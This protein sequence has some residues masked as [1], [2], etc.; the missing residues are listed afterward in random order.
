MSWWILTQ[1]VWGG[2]WD[3]SFLANVQ[4]MPMVLVHGSHFRKPCCKPLWV[5]LFVR[6]S[7]KHLKEYHFQIIVY[8]ALSPTLHPLPE[9]HLHEQKRDQCKHRV[10]FTETLLWSQSCSVM[11]FSE[12]KSPSSWPHGLYSPWNSPGQNTGVGSLSFL[13]GIFPTQGLNSGLP[14]YRWISYQLSHQEAQEYLSG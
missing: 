12:S 11:T 7:K 4:G 6:G 1:W 8:G 9:H 2:G 13:Q 5:Q 3:S 10:C 14:H